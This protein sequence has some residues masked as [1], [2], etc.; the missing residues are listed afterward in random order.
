MK[1]SAASADSVGS[2]SSSKVRPAVHARWLNRRLT[3]LRQS[4]RRRRKTKTLPHNNKAL[5]ESNLLE[6]SSPR[7]S[8]PPKSLDNADDYD[9]LPENGLNVAARRPAKETRRLALLEEQTDRASSSSKDE[10]EYALAIR[11]VRSKRSRP[12]KNARSH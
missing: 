3:A 9:R 5:S 2:A 10:D 12:R 1:K 7:R 4:R 6:A 11:E 8:K